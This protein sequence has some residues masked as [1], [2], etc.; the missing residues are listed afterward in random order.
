MNDAK[1]ASSSVSSRKLILPGGYRGIMGC[2]RLEMVGMRSRG[3]AIE[4]I[5]GWSKVYI[6]PSR[7]PWLTC[8][9]FRPGSRCHDHKFG[10]LL[11]HR[12]SMD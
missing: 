5:R 10:F 9:G 1:L 2:G 11:I 8:I 6:V 7:S 3:K 12:A 4:G